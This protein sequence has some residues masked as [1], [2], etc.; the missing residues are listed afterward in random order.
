MRDSHRHGPLIE[1][2]GVE[3]RWWGVHIYIWLA[4]SY[5]IH[6]RSGDFIGNMRYVVP[7]TLK[8]N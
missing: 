4:S 1:V 2:V 3:V 6:F 5:H 8:W 7:Y